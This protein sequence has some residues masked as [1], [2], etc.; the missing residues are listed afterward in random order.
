MNIC[1]YFVVCL[2]SHAQLAIVPEVCVSSGHLFYTFLPPFRPPDERPAQEAEDDPWAGPP[3]RAEAVD[4]EVSLIDADHKVAEV[5]VKR[6]SYTQKP[7]LQHRTT[8]TVPLQPLRHQILAVAQHRQ[9]CGSL[10]EIR[11][12]MVVMASHPVCQALTRTGCYRL[13]ICIL[14]LPTA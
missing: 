6:I 11:S 1:E 10:L 9:E 3:R 14:Q 4:M 7:K 2:W 13:R 12:L 5:E 8:E